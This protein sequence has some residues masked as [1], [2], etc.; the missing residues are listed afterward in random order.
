MH[1]EPLNVFMDAMRKVGS[2]HACLAICDVSSLVTR[3]SRLWVDSGS[4][5][6]QLGSTLESTQ[7]RLC[8]CVDSS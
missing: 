5:L 6:S 4:T 8:P 2:S 1:D 3:V 7:S